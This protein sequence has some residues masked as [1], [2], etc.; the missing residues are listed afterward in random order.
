M[1]PSLQILIPM[2]NDW[3]AVDGLIPALDQ[4][5][6][7]RR[8]SAEVWLVDDGSTVPVPTSFAAWRLHAIEAV[9][10]LRLR[11]NLGHQRAICIGLVTLHEE[12][13]D[14]LV[15]IM[16]GDGEDRPE[17]VARL[18]D[19]CRETGES[20]VVFAGRRKRSEGI[21]FR[22]LYTVFLWI[23][24]LLVGFRVRVG[25]FS[26]VPFRFLGSLVVV[27]ETWSHYAASVFR[28]RLP[29]RIVPTVRGRRAVGA[30]RMDLVALVVHGLSA[31]AVY[32]ETVGTRLLVGITGLT[33][34]AGLAI[35]AIGLLAI[36]GVRFPA[37]TGLLLGFLMVVLLQAVLLAFALA[38][39]VLYGRFSAS[40]VPQ[41]DCRH[42]IG[43]RLLVYPRRE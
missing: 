41:R 22:V 26:V 40:F 1:P 19:A 9:H 36:A 4:V 17:D 18:V 29:R 13:A 43:D 27:S 31:I 38:L 14:G 37:S 15:V 21:L 30:S 42:F 11:R 2:W 7:A 33:V 3:Q 23:H 8:W 6:A 12:R 10:L 28:A 24:F 5:L 34:V 35:G 20:E 16:D 32:S 25:N 39:F